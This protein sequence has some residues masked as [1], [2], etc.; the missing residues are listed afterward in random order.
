MTEP[1]VFIFL[2]QFDWSLSSHWYLNHMD[3]GAL[4]HAVHQGSLISSGTWL[5]AFLILSHLAIIIYLLGLLYREHTFHAAFMRV[6]AAAA[7]PQPQ[8]RMPRPVPM[9]SA[10]TNVVP[11]PKVNASRELKLAYGQHRMGMYKE[12]LEHY[13]VAAIGMH[14][15]LNTHLVGIRIHSEMVAEDAEFT[16]FLR[17]SLLDFKLLRPAAWRDIANYVE[18][19][20]PRL[21]NAAELK[22]EH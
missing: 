10:R 2:K 14:E 17:E 4:I 20:S 19:V 11:V 13:R 22:Q 3:A 16:R 18:A 8:N 1:S 7:T 21:L 12:A 15:E 9:K 6:E 5:T